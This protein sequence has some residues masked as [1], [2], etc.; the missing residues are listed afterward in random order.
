MDEDSQNH[1]LS[2]DD[3]SSRPAICLSEALMP[4][5]MAGLEQSNFSKLAEL[6]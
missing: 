3:G 2:M 5:S 6:T 1:M 4:K